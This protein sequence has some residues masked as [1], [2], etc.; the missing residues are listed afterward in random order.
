MKL[1]IPE[2][3]DQIILTNDWTFDLYAENRNCELGGT[4]GYN[5][6]YISSWVNGVY[7]HN[8]N[9]CFLW[10]TEGQVKTHVIPYTLPAGTVL[11]IDRIYIRKGAK[12]FSSVSFFITSKEK[13]KS[14]GKHL[15]FWAKLA[16]C[17]NIEF[18]KITA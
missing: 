7:I 18:E 14:T 5:V 6:R 8:S 13:I 1:Y 4:I 15:R 12:D 17:N 3:G 11:K 2:I 16:D 9:P 10:A